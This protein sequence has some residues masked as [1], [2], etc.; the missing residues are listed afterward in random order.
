MSPVG[1]SSGGSFGEAQM[2]VGRREEGKA[3]DLLCKGE[4]YKRGICYR[5]DN[6]CLRKD[7]ATIE[8]Y[9]PT[10]E[11]GVKVSFLLSCSPDN[12]SHKRQKPHQVNRSFP[13]QLIFLF[14]P[15][16]SCLHEFSR[17]IVAPH[18]LVP[19]NKFLSAA[20]KYNGVLMSDIFGKLSM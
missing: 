19:F 3:R 16:H 12:Q 15:S 8:I 4:I 2:V 11:D 7:C 13:S 14:S 10:R 20:L 18:K 1:W 9:F 17:S 5:L 6:V